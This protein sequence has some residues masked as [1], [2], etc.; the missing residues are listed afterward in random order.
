MMVLLLVVVAAML[1]NGMMPAGAGAGPAAHRVP[2]P[3]LLLF[4]VPL[5][6]LL[7]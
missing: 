6:V 4:R 5:P 3:V 2:L 1:T 7:L